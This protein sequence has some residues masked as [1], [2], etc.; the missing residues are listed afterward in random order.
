MKEFGFNCW[1]IREELHDDQEYYLQRNQEIKS[2]SLNLYLM[3]NKTMDW[4]LSSIFWSIAST[5]SMSLSSFCV[6]ESMRVSNS[7]SPAVLPLEDSGCFHQGLGGPM[8][9]VCF[10][11]SGFALSQT[12]RSSSFP[13]PVCLLLGQQLGS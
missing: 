7:S 9:I 5:R 13:L 2:H 1:S 4:W 3:K 6:N 12:S 11:Q 8:T 10:C